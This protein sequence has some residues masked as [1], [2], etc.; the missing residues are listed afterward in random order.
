MLAQS[1]REHLAPGAVHAH[2]DDERE[3]PTCKRSMQ[4]DDGR[5]EPRRRR[6]APSQRDTVPTT[7]TAVAQSSSAGWRRPWRRLPGLLYVMP[8]GNARP[9]TTRPQRRN[10]RRPSVLA[11]PPDKH[12]TSPE[13]PKRRR[14]GEPKIIPSPQAVIERSGRAFDDLLERAG[15]REVRA[16]TMLPVK[17]IVRSSRSPIAVRLTASARWS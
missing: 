13:Q 16:L 1:T 6:R 11:M 7:W 10:G 5:L 4:L 9:E 2:L 17:R 14:D 15:G 8:T 3:R 12:A